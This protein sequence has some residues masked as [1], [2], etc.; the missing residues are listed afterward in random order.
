[1]DTETFRRL[2]HFLVDW[3]ANYRRDIRE[4][5]VLSAAEPGDLRHALPEAPPDAP[6][7]FDAVFADFERLVMPGITH[8]N[9]PRFFAYFPANN[10]EPSILAEMMTAALGAQCMSWQTSPAATELE[11]VTMDWLASMLNLPEGF[12]GC[13]HD[14]ASVATLTAVLMARERATAFRFREEGAAAEGADRLR[15]YASSEAHSSV[16][17]AVFLAGIGRRNL[18]KVPTTAS[19]GLDVD[20]LRAAIASDRERG[21]EPACV[22]ATIGTTSTCAVD[23]LPDI[24]AFC[25][26]AGV[27]LHVDAAFAGSLAALPE[28]RSILDG[29]AQADSFVFNP[30]K[31]LFTN[32]DCSAH[33]V[34]DPDLLQATCAI[35]PEYLKTAHDDDVVNFRDWGIPLGRRFRALKLWWV[36]RSFG[37]AGIRARLREGLRL[38]DE[39]AER[40]RADSRFELIHADL[41]LVCFRVQR[42]DL[43]PDEED[44]FNASVLARINASGEAYLTHTRVFGRYVL[45]I[46][47]AQAMTTADDVAAAWKVIR[48]ASQGA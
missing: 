11:Q 17:K 9:H 33:F 37:V 44:A 48:Q 20:A 36:L 31:W 40:L 6:E 7:P 30:H 35:D 19:L 2:G 32:F 21:F 34:R 26:D 25:A 3:I 4:H 13:L 5:P 8:W 14:T 46:H 27:F 12:T 41:G 45:R 23:P 29:L 42:P 43:D 18:V 22:V 39:L 38:A 47:T 1:M 16:E 28:K 15:V 10:S 24:G